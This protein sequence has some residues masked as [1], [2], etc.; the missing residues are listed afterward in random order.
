MHRLLAIYLLA[1][2]GLFSGS[3]AAT[4][5]DAAVKKDDI[6]VLVEAAA[7]GER[8]KVS[9]LLR[10][11][12]IVRRLTQLDG[13]LAITPLHAAAA[14]GQVEIMRL[15]LDSGLPVDAK[16]DKG[17][18]PLHYAV[19]ER[20][21]EAVSL[22]L[23]RKANPDAKSGSTHFGG[24]RISTGH[25]EMTPLSLAAIG[26]DLA[27]LKL[28]LDSGADLDRGGNTA[29]ALYFAAASGHEEVVKYLLKRGA[30]VKMWITYQ[31][32]EDTQP[33]TAKLLR[34]HYC[35]H[36]MP[37]PIGIASLDRATYDI[38]KMAGCVR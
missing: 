5:P 20:Q 1:M 14:K 13:K 6:A 33:K 34:D 15:L 37:Q 38:R 36:E 2:I 23:E 17:Q 10:S 18:T 28:L 11:G 3:C 29:T 8:E 31:A 16:D 21:Q 24:E 19:G 22:L 35:R 30:K 7:N 25:A 4:K 12:E 27:M 32:I 26:G 9:G